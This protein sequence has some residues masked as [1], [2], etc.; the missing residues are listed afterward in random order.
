MQ[1]GGV[2]GAAQCLVDMA[3]TKTKAT[4]R[5]C[6]HA[7]THALNMWMALSMAGMAVACDG[8]GMPV[9]QCRPAESVLIQQR[10]PPSSPPI[11]PAHRL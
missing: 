10:L 11:P 3:R 4:H 1:C 5:E 7:C 2:H 9:P 6:R 8:M